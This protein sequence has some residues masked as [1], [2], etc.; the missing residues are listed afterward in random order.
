MTL[1][2]VRCHVSH[3]PVTCVTDLEGAVV[4]VICSAFEKE[5]RLCRLKQRDLSGGPL[6]QFLERAADQT[7]SS[8]D[9]RCDLAL[10]RAAGL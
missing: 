7:L 8:R 2:T 5:R 1:T 4:N 6:S 3:E 10:R 9:L